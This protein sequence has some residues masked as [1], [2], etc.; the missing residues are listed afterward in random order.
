M[1]KN[2]R[3]SCNVGQLKNPNDDSILGVQFYKTDGTKSSL[4]SKPLNSSVEI[5]QCASRL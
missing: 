5:V 1:R 2:N 3:I 4:K